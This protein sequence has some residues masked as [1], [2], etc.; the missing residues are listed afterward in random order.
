MSSGQAAVEVASSAVVPWWA[1]ARHTVRKAS[2]S[3]KNHDGG[4]ETDLQNQLGPLGR[5]ETGE[6]NRQL[7]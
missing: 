2:A 4:F 6:F 3:R 7:I 5:A 1:C